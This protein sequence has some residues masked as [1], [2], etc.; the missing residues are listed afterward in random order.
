VPG[1]EQALRAKLREAYFEDAQV[2]FHRLHALPSGPGG[3]ALEYVNEWRPPN[4]W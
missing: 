1:D 4:A 2:R 3:K